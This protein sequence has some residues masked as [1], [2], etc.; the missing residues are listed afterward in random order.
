[1]ANS[2]MSRSTFLK[3]AAMAGATIAATGAIERAQAD[4][5][6]GQASRAVTADEAVAAIDPFADTLAAPGFG[7]NL[8]L[9]WLPMERFPALPRS[10]AVAI[11]LH[12][13]PATPRP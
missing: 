12:R 13:I 10:P 5:A 9:P 8:R 1:M 2:T 6:A 7:N 3:T 4:E 11:V